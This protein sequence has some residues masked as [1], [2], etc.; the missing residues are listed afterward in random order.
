MRAK[1]G[2]VDEKSPGYELPENPI[3]SNGDRSVTRPSLHAEAL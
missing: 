3:S 2:P 1:F